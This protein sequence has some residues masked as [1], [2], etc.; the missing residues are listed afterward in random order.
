MLIL[1]SSSN[2]PVFMQGGLKKKSQMSQLCGA[3]NMVDS[4]FLFVCLF[5]S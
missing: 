1:V 3:H 2:C 4:L 5:V